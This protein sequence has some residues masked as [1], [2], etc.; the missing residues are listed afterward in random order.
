[1]YHIYTETSNKR[2][3]EHTHTH[4]RTNAPARSPT[5][6]IHYHIIRYSEQEHTTNL[7]FLRARLLPLGTIGII[8][9]QSKQAKYTARI[10]SDAM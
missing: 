4:T 8:K 6:T 9:Q 7:C 10:R 2:T 3:H 1:M 5:N